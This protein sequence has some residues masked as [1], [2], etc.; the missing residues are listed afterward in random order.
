VAS[1]LVIG[2]GNSLRRDDALGLHIAELARERCADAKI[3]VVHQLTPELAEAVAQSELTVFVDARCDRLDEGVLRRELAADANVTPSI[4]H[5]GAP[6]ALLALARALYGTAP[7]AFLVT[8]PAADLGV[9]LGL[10]ASAAC[11]VEAAACVVTA[12]VQEARAE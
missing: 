9:G 11:N 6:E 10:S 8:A 3:L 12:L 4:G 5:L 1:A 2:Y 7:R